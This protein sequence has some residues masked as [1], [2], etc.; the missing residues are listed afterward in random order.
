MD[1]GICPEKEKYSETA[2]PSQ[3]CLGS[4]PSLSD[5]I[6]TVMMLLEEVGFLLQEPLNSYGLEFLEYSQPV[7]VRPFFSAGWTS[8]DTFLLARYKLLEFFEDYWDNWCQTKDML[9]VLTREELLSLLE[10]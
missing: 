9:A 10:S 3:G 1:G 4:T 7:D 5:C 8:E 2:L 6:M